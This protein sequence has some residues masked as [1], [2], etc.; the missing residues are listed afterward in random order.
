MSNYETLFHQ[1]IISVRRPR[2]RHQALSCCVGA[3]TRAHIISYS[4]TM[5]QRLLLQTVWMGGAWGVFS[6]LSSGVSSP[7]RVWGQND[8]HRQADSPALSRCNANAFTRWVSPECGQVNTADSLEV[9]ISGLYAWLVFY[10]II[11]A[12]V[13][14]TTGDS[15]ISLGPAHCVAAYRFHSSKIRWTVKQYSIICWPLGSI[16]SCFTHLGTKK[17][18]ATG[19]QPCC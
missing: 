14:S 9:G 7:Y 11:Y 10:G 15:C 16:I 3:G 8:E 5:N 13:V 18:L 17:E 19:T 2:A 4:R 6:S 1:S 12:N